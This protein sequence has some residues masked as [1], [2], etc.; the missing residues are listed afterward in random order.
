MLVVHLAALCGANA[1]RAARNRLR[2]YSLN[3]AM[4]VLPLVTVT[5]FDLEAPVEGAQVTE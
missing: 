3:M 2:L 5:L 1:L 4:A